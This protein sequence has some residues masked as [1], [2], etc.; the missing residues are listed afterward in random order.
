MSDQLQ[1]IGVVSL[2]PG[3]TY[4][5]VSGNLR[6]WE[7]DPWYEASLSWKKS[8]YIHAGISGGTQ[9]IRGPDAQKL[10]SKV[11]AND[12]YKWGINRCKH[13]VMCDENGYIVNHALTQRNSEDEFRMYAGNPWPFMKEIQSGAY[14]A[15]ILMEQ[16]FVFQM[17]GPLSLT[18]IE[19]V[20]QESQRDVRFLD[21]K[22]VRIPGIDADLEL[23]RIGMSG[24]LAYEFRGPVEVGPQVYELICEAGK[25]YDLKRLGWKTYTVNHMEGGFPQMTVGFVSAAV[26]DPLFMAVPELAAIGVQP[27]TGSI[28]PANVRARLRTPGEVDWMWMVKFDHDFIGREALEKV[29]ANPKRKI[30]NLKWNVDDVMDIYRSLLTDGE[31]Y[32]ILEMP[33]GQPQPAGGHADLVTTPDGKEIGVSSCTTYSYY[34]HDLI[35]QCIIDVDES[36]LGNEVLVHW[37]DFGKKIKK[38][39]ATVVRYPYL[40][41]TANQDYDLSTVPSGVSAK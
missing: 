32:K 31:S 41:L 11:T 40:D 14:K 18:V 35:S 39:R 21:V 4:K 29:A 34:Y 16:A 27:Y 23:C 13:L 24:T 12:V 8:C 15:E 30:V 19:K 5:N 7:A 22:K 20:T 36:A 17:S 10:L 2:Q 3:V 37:G 25:E 28:D 33:C 1:S 6:V 26:V 38:V 9:V